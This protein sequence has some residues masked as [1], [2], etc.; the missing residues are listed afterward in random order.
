MSK[1]ISPADLEFILEKLT[2]ELSG[3]K[4][5]TVLLT[6]ATGFFGKWLTQTLIAAQDKWQLNNSFFILT[7]DR[8]RVSSES[9]WLRERADVHFLQ[10]DIRAFESSQS[11]STIIHGA[12]SASKDLNDNQPLV[13]FDTI[14]AGTK[15]VLKL[16]ERGGCKRLLLL[17]SGAVYGEQP[18]EISHVDE[19]YR[20]GPDPLSKNSAYGEAK[21]VSEFLCAETASRSRCAIKI[22]RCYAFVGPYLPLDT[23]F[24]A[25]NFMN[26][27]LRGE[28]IRI[29]GDGTPLRSY[30]YCADLAVWLF[31]ILFNGSPNV[32]YNVGSDHAV[33]I[34][35]LAQLIHE[36]GCTIDP[37]RRNLR[38]PITVAQKA[39]RTEIGQPQMHAKRLQYVPSIAR[40]KTD[41]G[42]SVWTPLQSAFQ[43]TLGWYGGASNTK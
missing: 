39:P 37:K 16:A 11:F 42:L 8:D 3:F 18:S 27:V 34:L 35:E 24:A 30:L 14:V 22:A 38:E 29:G 40:A 12:V 17:S 19:N 28:P 41:L 2:P 6:G 10:Q 26:A 1:P 20:G 7:R 31:K 21:R 23:H 13:M 15:Q 43:K 33:S 32:A 4:N 36:L 5:E 9:A 25:G